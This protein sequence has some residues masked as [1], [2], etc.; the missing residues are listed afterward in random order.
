MYRD[1]L[2]GDNL[3]L[4][5]RGR[6]KRYTQPA[7]QGPRLYFSPLLKGGWQKVANDNNQ[8]VLITEGE[9]KAA[10]GCVVGLLTI[11]LGGVYNFL[12]DGKLIL[13]FDLFDWKDR[14]VEICFDVEADGFTNHQVLLAENRL[15]YELTIRG[16]IV[17]I[18]R[19]PSRKNQKTGLDDYL[20]NHAIKDF[21]KLPR[22]DP[23]PPE[24]LTDAGNSRRFVRLRGEDLRFVPG[25]GWQCW[26]DGYWKSDPSAPMRAA[27]AVAQEIYHE[28]ARE[29]DD[30]RRAALAKWAVAS[31]SRQRLE[32]MIFL[33]Q[34]EPEIALDA[35][36][37]DTD[38]Y[39]LN[40]M[41][42]TIDLRSGELMAPNREDYITRQAPVTFDPKAKCL[43][44]ERT[45]KRIFDGNQKLISY[46]QRAFGY[47][48]T[49]DTSAKTLFFLYGP[50]GDNGKTT[51]VELKLA[52][53]G[54]Y[55][56]KSNAEILMEQNI[57]RSGGA[58]SPDLIS[59]RGARFV[60]TSELSD[61]KKLNTTAVKDLTG[62]DSISARSL[63]QAPI[64]FLPTHKLWMFG[65]H[66][67]II[68]GDDPATWRRVHLI[69]FT[70]SIPLKEQ[71][72]ELPSKL[73]SELPGI[74]NWVLH[75]C[76]EWQREGLNPPEEVMAATAEYRQQMD[77]LGQFINEECRMGV[78][79]TINIADLYKRYTKWCEDE[80]RRYSETKT[81]FVQLMVERGFKRK[82]G[83]KGIKLLA[84]LSLRETGQGERPKKY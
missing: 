80:G 30:A 3:P 33:A 65:N 37:L 7:G 14:E 54:P 64:T 38:P 51:A 39:L 67:P 75:G 24:S 62:G 41:N 47:S 78:R 60:V 23:N 71:D 17:K 66:K 48:L 35:D 6:A 40:V 8:T 63:Y 13:D 42:G 10:K 58:A 68:R 70:V 4:D 84:G 9:K 16:A 19:L 56:I 73:R 34:S 31:Q 18:V 12:S 28:A 22:L 61:G 1:R 79:E 15:A 72:R 36:A 45:L 57:N 25:L 52:L 5:K 76:R 55:G 29:R 74:L 26:S 83:A 53:L 77:T 2:I 20:V 50:R 32:A 43:L 46:I 21:Y 44:W 11:G 69:P 82:A 49:G 81:R 27:K 59:L